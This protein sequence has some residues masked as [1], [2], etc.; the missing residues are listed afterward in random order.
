MSKQAHRYLMIK[1]SKIKAH[2]FM[3]PFSELSDKFK[4]NINFNVV[5]ADKP[6]M[7]VITKNNHEVTITCD[8]RK[9]WQRK[10]DN[11]QE[12]QWLQK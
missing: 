11:Q 7:K 8:N 2:D 12:S 9:A 10:R 6:K 5:F 1:N 3:K 4:A